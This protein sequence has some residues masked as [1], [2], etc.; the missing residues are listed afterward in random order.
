MSIPATI[1][2]NF[3]ELLFHYFPRI[4]ESEDENR[5]H[6]DLECQIPDFLPTYFPAI[7]GNLQ[8]HEIINTKIQR[9][10]DFDLHDAIGWVKIHYKS[11]GF[12]IEV[13]GVNNCEISISYQHG[14]Y[15]YTH[16][17]D[18]KIQCYFLWQAL[19]VVLTEIYKFV[20]VLQAT[21][22][23]VKDI[24]IDYK[25]T[26]KQKTGP[27]RI[28][29]ILDCDGHTIAFAYAGCEKEVEELANDNQLG[30]DRIYKEL[31]QI[32]L[33]SAV[34]KFRVRLAYSENDLIDDEYL[35]VLG[36]SAE[37]ACQTVHD[38]CNLSPRLF[39]IVK[40]EIV[41]KLEGEF[42]TGRILTPT[43]HPF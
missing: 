23:E 26:K 16:N 28:F 35:E 7:A 6:F 8:L 34:R 41:G 10:L 18:D 22:E 43:A 37:Y 2:K 4:Y 20:S 5:L 42:L 3:A 38:V 39:E 29:R 1:D 40:I 11:Y 14:N 32:S 19:T 12:S 25:L 33:F 27:F 24:S 15:A 13:P 30:S 36:S 31:D 21:T 9:L 17:I